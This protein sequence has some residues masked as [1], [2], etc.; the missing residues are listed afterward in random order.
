MS[1]SILRRHKLLGWVVAIALIAL[2]VTPFLRAW[3]YGL[4][5][6]DDY[7]YLVNHPEIYDW[8]GWESLRFCF[9]DMRDC[10]W[11]P[12][13][14][15]SYALDYL[16]FGTW[17]GGFHIHS[18]FV[19]F[20]NSVLVFI[21]LR[22]IGN[23]ISGGRRSDASYLIAA[24]VWAVHPLRCESVVFL[25]SRK[26]VLSFFWELLALI[27]WVR[28][29]D[30]CRVMSDECRVRSAEKDAKCEVRVVGYTVVA[31]LFF[32]IGSM[33]KP[34]VM[35]FP[36]LCFLIDAFIFRRVSFLRFAAPVAYMLFLG[37]FAGYQQGVNGA[38]ADMFRQPLWGRLLGAC[39]AFG[40]YLKNTVWPLD[41]APQCIKTWPQLPRF[42]LPGLVLSGLVCWWLAKVALG[43]WNE[44]KK[45]VKVEYFE[46][47]PVRLVGDYGP[48]PLFV[49]VAWFAVAVAPM[50]GIKSFGFHAFADRFTYIPSVG[51]SI[52][53]V[54]VLD[55]LVTRFPKWSGSIM[56]VSAACVPALAGCTWRQTGFWRDDKTLFSHTLEVDG[57]QNTSAHSVL[58]TWSFE[59][60]HDLNRCVAEYE[61]V[62]AQNPDFAVPSYHIY[63]MALLELGRNE[64]IGD[65]MQFLTR[66]L[67]RQVDS[68]KLRRIQMGGEGLSA[69]ESSAHAV[70]LCC[71]AIWDMTDESGLKRA[72]EI[73]RELRNATYGDDASLV[74]L[75][76]LHARRCGDSVRAEALRQ[77]LTDSSIKQGYVQ[78]RFLK[79]EE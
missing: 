25:A 29:S 66:E 17:Y 20:L 41:L 6:L 53:L 35:T 33:C 64:E 57:D 23:S 38:T 51:L 46:D 3:N 14:W 67:A 5:D 7:P 24:L 70:Y 32:V 2:A 55:R 68:D 19:H 47:L 48:H 73:I 10:I 50:L 45:T 52:V 77:K 28:G 30:E 62:L 60:P 11:M 37:A 74:Y 58:A 12:L 13:T 39:A 44:R 71:R 1:W 75:D 42:W 54:V 16:L 40:I 4:I 15:L 49:G 8:N 56:A 34:S 59:F 65:K 63:L 27:C 36:V 22:Q 78:C 9:T 26:D 61:K 76:Y 18:I 21:L 69:W 72:G 43:Y 79:S 31:T